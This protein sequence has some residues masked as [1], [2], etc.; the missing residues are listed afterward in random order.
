[1]VQIKTWG[2]GLPCRLPASYAVGPRF[3]L[4]HSTGRY[5]SEPSLDHGE[6]LLFNIDNPNI[7][8]QRIALIQ[9]VAT[10]YIQTGMGGLMAITWTITFSF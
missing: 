5:G 9:E 10:F 7:D 4:R 3:I 6:R 1:M 8:G 2:G